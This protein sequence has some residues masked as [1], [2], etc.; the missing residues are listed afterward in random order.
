MLNISLPDQIQPF[1]EERAIAAGFNS[2]N[3]YVYHLIVR[4]QERIA[5]QERIESLLVEGLE[6]GEPLEVTDDW[7]EHRRIKAWTSTI[8]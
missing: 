8:V 5:Q 2:A 6:S 1:L 3:D 4:E 7:W